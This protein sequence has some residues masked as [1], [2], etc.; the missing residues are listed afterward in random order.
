MSVTN[1]RAI[2]GRPSFGLFYLPV[3]FSR[4]FQ[5]L[6]ESA[7]LP[8]YGRESQTYRV[9]S[10]SQNGPTAQNYTQATILRQQEMTHHP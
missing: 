7:R 2:I 5:D 3:C 1:L 4:P 9:R 8:K 6:E 10:D